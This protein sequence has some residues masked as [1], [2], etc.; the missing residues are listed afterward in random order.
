VTILYAIF[1]ALCV[2]ITLVIV[3]LMIG[4]TVFDRILAANVMGTHVVLLI[5]VLGHIMDTFFFIDIALIYALVNFIT[6]IALLR[7]FAQNTP[8]NLTPYKR[9]IYKKP[10]DDSIK[11]YSKE[12]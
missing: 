6:T 4:K 5:A 11:T 1:L 3:R 7:Y 12:K 8:E 9:P 10:S 2:S